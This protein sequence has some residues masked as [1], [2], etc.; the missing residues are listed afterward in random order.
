MNST[1][2]N[3]LSIAALITLPMFA[4]AGEQKW[5]CQGVGTN[6][7]EAIGDKPG[8]SVQISNYSCRTEGGLFDGAVKN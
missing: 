3:C 8:H 4:Q 5:V 1:L 6:P 2:K 7:A